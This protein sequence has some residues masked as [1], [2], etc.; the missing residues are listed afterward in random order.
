MV[1]LLSQGSVHTMIL[2]DEEAHQFNAML[3]AALAFQLVVVAELVARQ[4]AIDIFFLDWEKPRRVMLRG[5]GREAPAPVSCWRTL[6][7]A[8][9]WNELQ[10]ERITR[11]AFT[12]FFLVRP[13]P[14]GFIA[15]MI[16]SVS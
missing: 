8:N 5:G 11:P 4:S 10:S 9:E 3:A 1:L 2:Q 16:S 6:F 12:L 7:I 13:C 14:L 15:E